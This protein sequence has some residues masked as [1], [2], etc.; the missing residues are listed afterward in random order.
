MPLHTLSVNLAE[1]IAGLMAASQANPIEQIVQTRFRIK[2]AESWGISAG[3]KVLE[4]GCGQGDTTAVLAHAV[5]ADGHVTAVDPAEP[6]YGSPINL[7]DSTKHLKNGPLGQRIEF[8]LS[9]DPLGLSF[10]E[11]TFDFVVLAHCSWYFCSLSLLRE[12]LLRARRWG[13][14]LCI[15]E[16]DLEPRSPE[17][18]AHLLAIL[19]QG[20]VEAFR[21]ESSSNVRSPFSRS[22]LVQVVRD[23]GWTVLSET[24]M[25]SSE[26][27]DG[28]WE[29]AAVLSESLPA[30]ASLG[31]PPR[32]LEFVNSEGEML[33]ELA[34]RS[35]RKS[36]D[37]F[38]IV[39]E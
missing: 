36:L 22:V 35:R 33:R 12:T 30:V 21:P 2:L 15:S 11:N 29:T 31:M 5:H 23:A 14:R 6:D 34:A 27:A 24:S 17:Q 38:S 19:I 25:D 16:W 39:A 4:I 10:A 28:G 1:E 20:Q 3:A 32:L 9:C 26:L 8:R 18:M 37:S 13:R 7:G